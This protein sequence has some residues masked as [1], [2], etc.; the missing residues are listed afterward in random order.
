MFVTCYH[1]H[2]TGNNRNISCKPV[3]ENL[4]LTLLVKEIKYG[5]YLLK[6][7]DTVDSVF[8]TFP[9]LFIVSI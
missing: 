2:C 6:L 7:H 9:T 4:Y 1:W 3:K 5:T 8:V